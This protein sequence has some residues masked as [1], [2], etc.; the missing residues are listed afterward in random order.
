MPSIIIVTMI[1]SFSLSFAFMYRQRQGQEAAVRQQ[2]P[3]PISSPA[4]APSAAPPRPAAVR[5]AKVVV[6][7]TVSAAVDDAPAMP[8]T[9][10][11]WNRRHKNKIQASLMNTSEDS[12]LVQV[13]IVNHSTKQSSQL[14]FDLA[15]HAQKNF[16]TDDGLEMN[17]GDQITLQ[18]PP[19]QDL[20]REVP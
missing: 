19:Y 13:R 15:P 6:P 11:I 8:V 7:P 1:V 18:S 16:S 10:E 5:R 14:A 20:T 4:T 17:S 3:M 2:E 12:L 9:F